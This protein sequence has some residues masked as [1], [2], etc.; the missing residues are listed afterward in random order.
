MKRNGRN[1]IVWKWNGPFL[2][3]RMGRQRSLNIRWEKIERKFSICL[4][5][6][7]DFAGVKERR[8]SS[9]R[10]KNVSHWNSRR[11]SSIWSRR[12]TKK[13]ERKSPSTDSASMS[14]WNETKCWGQNESAR[15]SSHLQHFRTEWKDIRPSTRPLQWKRNQRNVSR[16]RDFL[17]PRS[18]RFSGKARRRR[19]EFDESPSH[20]I[21]FDDHRIEWREQSNV[22]NLPF[23]LHTSSNCRRCKRDSSSNSVCSFQSTVPL[24]LVGCLI[25]SSSSSS[26]EFTFANPLGSFETYFSPKFVV[27][28]PSMC[29]P[30]NVTTS[31]LHCSEDRSIDRMKV[32]FN[33][34]CNRG[35]NLCKRT[36]RLLVS[37]NEIFGQGENDGH[38]LLI[39]LKKH[40]CRPH[41]RDDQ[42]RFV[43]QS[44]SADLFNIR[45]WRALNRISSLRRHPQMSSSFRLIQFRWT[46]LHAVR[47]SLSLHIHIERDFHVS[48]LFSAPPNTISTANPSTT[49]TTKTFSSIGFV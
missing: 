1:S 4:V 48:L 15:F 3:N 10:W 40:C 32:D 43:F 33:G 11:N 25:D 6:S 5:M 42:G 38:L 34:F 17:P 49:T 23:L 24:I 35:E 12:K 30:F 36:T 7:R 28:V 39:S 29:S 14:S 26:C 20:P 2:V 16:W 44:K 18:F 41:H 31:K 47:L 13:S 46:M 8:R 45:I 27:N 37:T 21:E 22:P 19:K 9:H